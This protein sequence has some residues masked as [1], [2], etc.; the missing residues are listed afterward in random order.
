MTDI[1]PSVPAG[2]APETERLRAAILSAIS[3][4]EWIAEEHDQSLMVSEED[5]QRSASNAAN[6]LR[7][8]LESEPPERSE[9]I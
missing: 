2:A 1:D 3:S 9:T 7:A 4:L 6:E 8:A 5:R